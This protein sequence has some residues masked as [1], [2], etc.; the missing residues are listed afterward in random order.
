MSKKDNRQGTS[1]RRPGGV[2]ADSDH[3]WQFCIRCLKRYPNNQQYSHSPC[4]GA[5]LVTLACSRC[6]T[7]VQ[8]SG[9][10]VKCGLNQTAPQCPQCG[11][12]VT[13]K[14]RTT[15]NSADGFVAA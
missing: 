11:N 14:S 2:M 13:Q 7:P 10:C 15:R 6:C 12:P 8:S 4:C 1:F 3:L 5:N 9:A